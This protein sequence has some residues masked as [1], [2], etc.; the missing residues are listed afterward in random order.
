VSR[1]NV[2]LLLC[3]VLFTLVTKAEQTGPSVIRVGH[4]PNITHAQAVVGRANR[5]FDKALAPNVLVEWKAFNAGPAV[6]EA[7]FAGELDMAYVGSMPAVTGY[8]RSQGLALKVVAGATSGGAALIV[9]ADSGINKAEDFHGKR[10]ATPQHF[11]ARRPCDLEC[12]VCIPNLAQLYIP[13][14][15]NDGG[16]SAARVC[17]SHVHHCN[18]RQSS[19]GSYRFYNLCL[20][21]HR[22]G[23][24]HRCQLM[25]GRHSRD[26]RV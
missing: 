25:V 20:L 24:A 21:W 7:L 8:V 9:R 13:L 17:R 10:I 4:F 5:W 2:S 18:R 3:V 14:S 16:R 22:P 19:Q 12:L 26:S 6:I 23:S 1:T 11:H 15:E